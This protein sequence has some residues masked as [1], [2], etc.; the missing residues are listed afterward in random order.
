MTLPSPCL[1]KRNLDVFWGLLV[2]GCRKQLHSVC[3]HGICMT[4]EAEGRFKKGCFVQRWVHRRGSLTCC[5]EN[6]PYV[7][8]SNNNNC[9]EKGS[10][11][12]D[13]SSDGLS[14]PA[15][16]LLLSLAPSRL[17]RCHRAR[18]LPEHQQ[19]YFPTSPGCLSE[20]Q[21]P[22]LRPSKSMSAFSQDSYVISE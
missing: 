18:Q 6:I 10:G 1:Q 3:E 8:S 7:G 15:R 4:Q 9:G 22:C 14:I 13:T 2:S 21:C 20:T 17:R 16:T 11:E 5:T 12:R 19:P